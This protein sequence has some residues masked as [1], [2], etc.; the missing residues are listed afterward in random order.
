MDPCGSQDCGQ[1]EACSPA[2]GCLLEG[3]NLGFDLKRCAQGALAWALGIGRVFVHWSEGVAVIL[4]DS[5]GSRQ[6]DSPWSPVVSVGE[7][8][9]T[10]E[11]ERAPR[12]D[13]SG[14]PL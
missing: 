8:W 10:T 7:K 11:P 2:W 4:E 5:L 13:R 12:L 9:A 6:E 1:G 3:G 14:A